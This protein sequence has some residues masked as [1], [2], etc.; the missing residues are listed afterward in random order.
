MEDPFRTVL[1]EDISPF[2]F[3]SCDKE[4]RF[5]LILHFIHFLGV[6]VTD[7][8][9][10]TSP[11]LLTFW[12]RHEKASV[13]EFPFCHP[14]P[15]FGMYFVDSS[16]YRNVGEEQIQYIESSAANKKEFIRYNS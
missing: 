12:K 4:A 3:E 10:F 15:G 11:L 1:F 13:F 7:K 2:L 9:I 16:W 14:N 8:S 6:P 5:N